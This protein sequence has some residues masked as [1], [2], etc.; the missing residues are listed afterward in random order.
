[1]CKQI[2]HFGTV[3]TEGG[4]RGKQ[5][6]LCAVTA[7]LIYQDSADF[8]LQLVKHN[9]HIWH[10]RVLFCLSMPGYILIVVLFSFKSSCGLG[11]ILWGLAFSFFLS[12]F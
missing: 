1:M 2:I 11:S 4:L 3:Q 10:Q 9:R 8:F 6:Y 5:V 7:L 12:S